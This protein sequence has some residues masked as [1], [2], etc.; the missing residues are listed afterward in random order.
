[1]LYYLFIYGPGVQYSSQS[2]IDILLDISL[3]PYHN[4]S[5]QSG[6]A[7]QWRIHYCN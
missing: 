4:V 7:G 2:H 1:M 3:G 6:V 5:G